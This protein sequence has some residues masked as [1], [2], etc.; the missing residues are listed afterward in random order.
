MVNGDTTDCA[1]YAAVSDGAGNFALTNLPLACTGPQLIGFNGTTATAPPAIYAAVNLVFTLVSGQVTASAVLVHLPRIDNVETFQV[2]QNSAVNQTYAF[3]TIPGLSVTVYA[4]TTFTMPDGT[5]PNPFPL[6]AV[7]VP[8]DRLPDNKPNVPTMI[9]AFIVAFQPANA[10]TNQP[11]AVYFPNTL[12]TPP[13]TDMALMTLDPTHGQMVPY[14]TGAVSADSTQIV[15][16]ADPAHPGHLYGLVHFDWHG[17]MPPAPPAPPPPPPGGCPNCCPSGG[18]GGGGGGPD[19]PSGGDPVDLS[20]GVQIVRSKDIEI[21]GPRGSILIGRVYRSL[22]TNP[23]P[24][25]IRSGY[26]Y[27]YELGTGPY[28]KGQGLINLV[29]PNGNQ[30]P[31]TLQ[32]NGSLTNSTVPA[33]R[34]VVIT[35]PSLEVYNLR[36]ADGKTMQFQSPASGG[37]IAYLDSITDPNGNK[38]TLVHGNPSSPDQVTQVIDPV[39]RAF[40]LVYDGSDRITS[41]TDPIG[42]VVAYTYNSQGTLG[43]VTDPAGGV[44]SYSYDSQNRLTQ[45]T[46]ARGIAVAQNTFDGNGRVIQQVQADGGVIKFA[47]TLINPL[48]PMSPVMTTLMTDPLGN[49]STYRFDPTGLLLGVTDP[50]G[51][52]RVFARDP[53]H[54]NLVTASM[55][56]AT[57]QSC[58]LGKVGDQFF[59]YDQN[60]NTLTK[61]DA[62]GNTTTVTHEPVFN[63]VTSVTDPLGN[64]T[65]FTYDSAGNILTRTDPNGH[66]SSYAYNSFGQ[67]IRATDALGQVSTFTYDFLGDLASATDPL[68]NTTFLQS[69]LVSRL[70][71]VVDPLNRASTTTFDA[72]DRAVKLVD[73]RGNSTLYTYDAVGDLLSATDES[74]RSTIYT[75]DPMRRPATTTDPLGKV[76]SLTHDFNGNLIQSVD[77]RDQTSSLTYDSFKSP[78]R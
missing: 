32:P 62:L 9:R 26:S 38:V 37:L 63:K 39:G 73:R 44:T 8:V 7:Q 60:G 18:G 52:T 48:A 33:M 13:G 69:D 27:G 55:G 4:G 59:T 12:N 40:T 71:K 11:V 57:C 36:F 77:R 14:G 30:Y 53:Q 6:A 51:Q 35:S 31:F 25:G 2:T 20:T 42:R 17:P 41:V 46:D 5:Q 16:D 67:L 64:V 50:V 1:G 56:A 58:G 70:V 66:T 3:A 34:G 45:I 54:Q 47:Y 23:G 10:T 49:S 28:V 15:P 72:L 75:F 21:R 29:M 19:G 65:Q 68:G 76:Q 24:F 43:T 74:G 22:S 78:D 61:T